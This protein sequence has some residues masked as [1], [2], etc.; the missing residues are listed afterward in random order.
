[1]AYG[2]LFH[3]K[4]PK[5]GS[6]CPILCA[7]RG[8]RGSHV[9]LRVVIIGAAAQKG[10]NWRVSPRQQS[11]PERLPNQELPQ[12]EHA[13]HVPIADCYGT[14]R[15][16]YMA[17]T[18]TIYTFNID[19]AD[20][21][22][23]R[24]ETL[25]LRV[26]QQP[27]ETLEYMLS[28]VLAYCL[29]YTEGIAFTQ[30]VAAG[31]EPAIWVRDLTGHMLAWIEVGMPDADRLHRASKQANRVA[32]YTHR[33]PELL[34]QQLAGKRIHRAEEI[35]IYALEYHVMAALVA[36]LER[37]TRMTLSVTERQLYIDVAG[38]SI[39]GSLVEHRVG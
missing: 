9:R 34:K 28:R 20:V 8:L 4:P 36:A 30:G 33:N 23:G 37:R 17:L 35:P 29:E 2:T 24:Y 27:S 18:A 12:W 31:D 32:I 15:L 10:G 11:A 38:Q 13:T 5:S 16:G 6:A 26:A 3:P 25:D 22:R 7:L 21:D 39:V 1:M 19:L 14:E